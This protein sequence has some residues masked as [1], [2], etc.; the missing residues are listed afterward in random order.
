MKGTRLASSL[1]ISPA[2]VL[3]E[4]PAEIDAADVPA[5]K[6]EL[7]LLPR[8]ELPERLS[9]EDL[10]AEL[11]GELDAKLDEEAKERVEALTDPDNWSRTE[12]VVSTR[13]GDYVL[14]AATPFDTIHRDITILTAAMWL[15]LAVL[16]ALNAV[17][18]WIITGRALRPVSHIVEGVRG[19]S[20]RILGERVPE[21]DSGDEV[22]ELARTMNGMLDRIEAGVRSQRQFVSDASHELRSP[23]TA[24][25]TEAEI[26]LRHPESSVCHVVAKV[27]HAEGERL[28]RLVGDLLTLAS[29]DENHCETHRILDLDDLVLEAAARVN[30]I[31]VRTVDVSA[32]RVLG[33]PDQ[34][35]RLVEN[36]L[37]NAA[38]H[39]RSVVEVAL[40]P[41]DGQA[42]LTVDDDGSGVPA[43]DRQ[44]VFE[45]FT[46][47]E[48][49]RSRDAGGTGLGLSLVLAVTHA[50]G[51]EVSLTGC[52]LG[53]ARFR[54]TL[55]LAED[56]V[57]L[58]VSYASLPQPA[59]LIAKRD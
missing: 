37:T 19:I 20:D 33:N 2:V 55:P 26:A 11:E 13:K 6:D 34:L 4:P 10:P 1:G 17:V 39:A 52:P 46:R 42:V 54:V 29:A 24:I 53:G 25:I 30:R 22:E 31:P 44:R 36:L 12:L 21:P 43:A 23:I 57:A 32:A 7:G 59:K 58:P 8:D 47:L 56:A 48:E 50:H 15:A 35:S 41:V 45:R 27:A 16:V 51:G 18:A 3:I 49:S 40:L 28:E 9:L 38:R 5:I 14:A